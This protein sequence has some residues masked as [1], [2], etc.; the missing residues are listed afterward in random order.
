MVHFKNINPSN[1]A[2]LFLGLP[3][4]GHDANW[5]E[6]MDFHRTLTLQLIEK[7]FEKIPFL[8]SKL[9]RY[10][11]DFDNCSLFMQFQNLSGNTPVRNENLDAWAS[12]FFEY[13]VLI[14]KL[15]AYAQSNLS[16]YRTE[17]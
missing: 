13:C 12:S 1:R 16:T 10:L 5:L 8:D 17:N 15:D 3:G 6:Y 11:A 2:P 14:R 7:L 9:V 4:S